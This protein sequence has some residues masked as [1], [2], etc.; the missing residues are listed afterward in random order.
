MTESP[1]AGGGDRMD[2]NEPARIELT[3]QQIQALENRMAKPPC[4]VNPQTKETFASLRKDEY[5]RLS[6]EPYD[7]IAWTSTA[8]AWRLRLKSLEGWRTS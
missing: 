3:E 1:R 7:D 8:I 6:E 5:Q 2:S 4:I